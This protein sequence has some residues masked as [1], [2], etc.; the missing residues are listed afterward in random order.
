MGEIVSGRLLSAYTAPSLL[1]GSPATT[2]DATRRKI[3][4]R[5]CR[6]RQT[7]GVLIAMVDESGKTVHAERAEDHFVL[8]A[9][10]FDET[11]RAKA[12]ALHTHLCENTGSQR[13][14]TGLHF[15]DI[16][17]HGARRYMTHAL[18]TR[19]WITIVSVV[20]C[21]RHLPSGD[22]LIEDVPAQYNYTFRF[23]L[24][25]LSWI[26]ERRHTQLT[27]VAATLGSAPPEGLASYEQA[28]RHSRTSIKWDHLTE[29]AGIML[30]Q[31]DEPLLNLADIAASA[32]AKAVEPDSWGL[33]EPAYLRNLAPALYRSRDGNVK[34][35]GIKL[36]P[37]NV[38]ERD[39]YTLLTTLGREPGEAISI[40]ARS[41]TTPR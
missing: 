33:V 28:L 2:Y 14:R 13:A 1:D 29:P 16:A 17:S 26:A 38:E 9:V 27:Y 8:S 40:P 22:A 39:P 19:D 24:E 6:R 35:Y 18:G 10:V 31:A 25:R 3:Q 15:K 4:D 32:T 11:D 23:L 20:V 21:K 34:R 30:P 41:T 7:Q 36:H 37:S 12:E 5:R